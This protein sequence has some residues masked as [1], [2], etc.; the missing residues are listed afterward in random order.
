MVSSSRGMEDQDLL[1]I[2]ERLRRDFGEGPEYQEV[3]RQLPEDWP[4]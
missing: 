3:R 4:M 1:E 2:L